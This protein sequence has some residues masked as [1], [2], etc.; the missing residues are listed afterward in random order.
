MALRKRVREHEQRLSRH[1]RVIENLQTQ[2]S[3]MKKTVE[4][5]FSK[6]EESNKHL[7]DINMEQMKQNSEILNAILNKNTEADRRSDELKKEMAA[8]SSDLKKLATENRWK[9]ILG[10][11]LSGPLTALVVDLISKALC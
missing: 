1:D 3:D 10:I 2:M 5:S 6:I 11:A 4:L 9:L 7:R 8:R